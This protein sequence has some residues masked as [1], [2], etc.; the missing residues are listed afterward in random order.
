MLLK[1]SVCMVKAFFWNWRFPT[2][3]YI[4]PFF[5]LEVTQLHQFFRNQPYNYVDGMLF[6]LPNRYQLLIYRVHGSAFLKI[7]S[8]LLASMELILKYGTNIWHKPKCIV[9]WWNYLTVFDVAFVQGQ[10]KMVQIIS[11]QNVFYHWGE[12][13]SGSVYITELMQLS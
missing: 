1:K 11:W 12:F 2:V 8:H 3:Q 6:A 4:C 5:K 7:E 13:W 9:S 10:A